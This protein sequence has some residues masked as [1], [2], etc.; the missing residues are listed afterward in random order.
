M[1]ERRRG[2]ILCRL[3]KFAVTLD[4]EWNEEPSLSSFEFPALSPILANHRKMWNDDEKLRCRWSENSCFEWE[5]VL[6]IEGRSN[7]K[8]PTFSRFWFLKKGRVEQKVSSP[9]SFC[10]SF[11][12]FAEPTTRSMKKTKQTNQTGKTMLYGRLELQVNISIWGCCRG[13]LLQAA[14]LCGWKLC[15]EHIC[16]HVLEIWFKF[17]TSLRLI[18]LN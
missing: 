8:F 5:K 3:V 2:R 11:F 15:Q 10:A 17:L 12:V 6:R 9:V 1:N 16:C 4:D 18:A 7:K 14:S 13:W